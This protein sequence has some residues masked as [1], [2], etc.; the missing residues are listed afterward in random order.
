[1]P[2]FSIITPVYNNEKYIPLAA[3]SVLTQ[4][5]HDFEYII[6]DDG[7]TDRTS[8]IVDQIAQRDKRVRVIHQTN[9]WI[10][11]SFNNGIE[12]ASGDY[13]YIVNSDDKLRPGALKLAAQKIEQYHPDVIW[14]KVLVHLCDK[15]QVILEYDCHQLENSV[16][17]ECYYADDDSVHKNW[18]YFYKSGLAQNQANFYRRDI[19]SRNK[20]RNDVYGADTLFNISIANDIHSALV[21]K[22]AVYDHFLYDSEKMNISVGKYYGYEHQ[23]FNEFYLQYRKLFDDWKCLDGEILEFIGTRRIQS[24]TYEFKCMQFTGCKLTTEE[25]TAKIFGSIDSIVYECAKEL[26]MLEELES[27][28]LSGLR[29]LFIQESLSPKSKMYFVY[30]M[31]ESLLRYEKDLDDRQKIEYAIQHPSNK[32][33]L[34]KIFYDRLYN[35][36]D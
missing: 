11:A 12:I 19:M 3:E 32:F 31:L 27:R 34:G 2:K 5:Y 35:T 10:Y 23:M 33:R 16:L 17:G 18:F 21:M 4:D 9:Q 26:D 28:I 24:I 29:E 36:F 6:V 22:E 7:S 13:I 20:F 14:T 25:K 30:E 1:M 8:E 15:E